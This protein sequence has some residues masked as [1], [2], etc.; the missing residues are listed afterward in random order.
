MVGE[1][2]TIAKITANE[3]KASCFGLATLL[4]TVAKE[5]LKVCLHPGPTYRTD[6]TDFLIKLIELNRI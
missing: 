1:I 4:A 3:R 6:R 5:S 2:A